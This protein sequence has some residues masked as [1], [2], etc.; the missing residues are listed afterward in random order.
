MVSASTA[1]IN[2]TLIND[3]LLH[4]YT[5]RPSAVNQS[6]HF[7][8]PICSLLYNTHRNTQD[9]HSCSAKDQHIYSYAV[10]F[11]CR[12]DGGLGDSGN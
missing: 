8:E 9:P 3:S 11:G 7:F 12:W 10:K 5:M 6:D 2:I 4:T 1:V